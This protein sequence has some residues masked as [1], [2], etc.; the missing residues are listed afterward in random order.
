MGPCVGTTAVDGVAPDTAVDLATAAPPDGQLGAPQPVL[1]PPPTPSATPTLPAP[2]TPTPNDPVVHVD[3]PEI[4]VNAGTGPCDRPATADANAG[5]DCG[6]H[7]PGDHI[8]VGAAGADEQSNTNVDGVEGILYVPEW[9]KENLRGQSETAADVVLS[10]E[11]SQ[12]RFFQLGWYIS[13][14]GGQLDAADTPKA[15]FGEGS[16]ADF[17]ET[18]TTLRGVPVRPG[19]HTFRIIHVNSTDPTFDLHYDAYVDN[20]RVWTSV[21][22]TTAEA[23]PSVVA[24]TNWR[25]ADMWL[26]AVSPNQGAALFG[27]HVNRAWMPWAEY[28]GSNDNDPRTCWAQQPYYKVTATGWD[29]C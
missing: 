8:V 14:G 3:P 15:F 17:G 23:T 26:W 22:A 1:P 16:Y 5:L 18:L 19:Y 12:E 24:E 27:H 6:A 10:A 2:A 20:S 9:T 7:G 21:M 28:H 25:C 13:A 4:V 11:D 29:K